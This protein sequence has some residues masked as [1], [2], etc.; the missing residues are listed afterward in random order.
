MDTQPFKVD[1]ISMLP[2]AAG[3]FCLATLLLFFKEL[4]LPMR[5]YLVPS[6]VPYVMGAAFLSYIQINLR[7]R[8]KNNIH[9]CVFCT[10]VLLHAAWIT[11]FLVYNL[12]RG[13]I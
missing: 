10:F 6:L 12:W 9:P 7:Q 13:S 3:A 5:D 2:A 4:T 11:A 8:R 1:N